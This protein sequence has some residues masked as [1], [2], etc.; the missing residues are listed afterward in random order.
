MIKKF[1]IYYNNYGGRFE[2]TSDLTDGLFLDRIAPSIPLMK[3]YIN[4]QLSSIDFGSITAGPPGPTGPRGS[5]GV[6]GP[7]GP[8]GPT[9][10]DGSG[11]LVQ[12]GNTIFNNYNTLHF[13]S[14]DFVLDQ[15]G[16][17][18]NIKSAI[19][20]TTLDQLDSILGLLSDT[21]DQTQVDAILSS[22]SENDINVD[23]ET[24]YAASYKLKSNRSISIHS[25]VINNK[26]HI[27]FKHI[28]YNDMFTT[29]TG[30]D[31]TTI[32]Q[33][34]V[35]PDVVVSDL[36][37]LSDDAYVYTGT[38][39]FNISIRMQ[40]KYEWIGADLPYKFILN[41]YKMNAAQRTDICH[42]YVGGF[43]LEDVPNLFNRTI[44]LTV[45]PGDMF[46]FNV[47]KCIDYTIRLLP[48]S[49]ICFEYND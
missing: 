26:K 47:H 42:L 14:T 44:M 33:N 12:C 9:G 23:D 8:Q 22:I 37:T 18:I 36:F 25:E 27:S 6:Q 35:L 3:T 45:T 17:T 19:N 7:T 28:K 2:I 34:L 43:D 15:T 11:S 38:T 13:L 10:K 1:K 32:Q 21:Y 4:S 31:I 5:Q 41:A 24:E 40:F 20:T 16:D 29:E 46:Y 39:S 49:Y 30:V 48:N